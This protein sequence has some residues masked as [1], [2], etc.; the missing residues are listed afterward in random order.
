MRI[1]HLAKDEALRRVVFEM[2]VLRA[3]WMIIILC[4]KL[5]TTRGGWY[6]RQCAD[7]NDD[8]LNHANTFG[9]QS[10]GAST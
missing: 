6:H 1:D 2:I 4:A 10:E 8:M 9:N 3:L 5:I 7:I